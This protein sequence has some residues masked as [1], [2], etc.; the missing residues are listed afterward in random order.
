MLGCQPSDILTRDPSD[1]ET[2]IDIF[3]DLPEN[4]ARFRGAM[5][6][7]QM[8][9]GVIDLTKVKPSEAF[10]TFQPSDIVLIAVTGGVGYLAKEAFKHFFPGTPSVTEQIRVLG[11]LI[12]TGAKVGAQSVKVRVSTNTQLGWQMPKAVK[13][14]KILSENSGTIDLEIVFRSRRTR[15]TRP[16]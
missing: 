8:P 4:I 12:E 10:A 9:D 7:P 16:A 2:A 3:R 14:A 6:S 13:E 5:E 1:Y 11:E 15:N